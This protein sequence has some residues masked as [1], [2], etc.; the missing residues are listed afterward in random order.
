VPAGAPRHLAIGSNVGD[1]DLAEL[2]A[3]DMPGK[4]RPWRDIDFEMRIDVTNNAAP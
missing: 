1:L 4:F 2:R 3:D